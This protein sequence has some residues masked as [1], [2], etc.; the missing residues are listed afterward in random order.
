VIPT[1]I[2]GAGSVQTFAGML[3]KISYNSQIRTNRVG[4]IV[5]AHEF[6]AHPLQELGHRDLLSL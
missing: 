6:F 4:G 5:T 3:L 2:I 1:K